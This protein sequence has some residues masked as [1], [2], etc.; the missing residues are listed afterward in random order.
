M[1][2]LAN[3]TRTTEWWKKEKAKEL[4][5]V[6]VVN[7]GMGEAGLD[8]DPE[9]I[10]SRQLSNKSLVLCSGVGPCLGVAETS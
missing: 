2:H 1:E 7:P 3:D 8:K 4:I 9:F 10:P 6:Q 5:D